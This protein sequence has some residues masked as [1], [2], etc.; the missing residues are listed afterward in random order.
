MITVCL[1]LCVLLMAGCAGEESPYALNDKQNFTV[2]IKYDANG[3]QFTTNTSVI[4]D[5][6]NISQLPANN[7]QVQLALRSPD[8][9][10][11]GND[12]FEAVRND[13]FLAGW[14]TQCT[15]KDGQVTYSGKWDFAEDRLDVNVS[16]DYKSAEPVLTL[17][18][19][20]VPLFEIQFYDRNSGE[21]LDTLQYNPLTESEITVPAWS[22]ETGAMEL[23]DFP[24]KQGY[25][26]DKAYYDAEGTRP[27]TTATLENLGSVNFANGTATNPVTKVYVDWTE[28]A[29]YHIYNVDQ[30]LEHA[31]TDGN[32]VIHADLDFTDKIWPTALMYGNFSGTI[33]GNGH[34]FSNVSVTQTNNSKP[35]AGLFG[36]LTETAG[37][38][39][40]KLENAV[41]TIQG[42]TRVMG[43]S[44]GLL[45]GTISDQAT[46]TGLEIHNSVL[47]I[48]SGCYFGV[49][50]YTIGLVCGMGNAAK[51]DVADIQCKAVGNAPDSV[52]I[53]VN[54]NA[55]SVE[56]ISE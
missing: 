7:G 16:G 55:V 25:T 15:E 2:S 28:G 44:F 49:D 12:A 5:S 1:L 47:Q 32:Y 39:D 18:A 43:T 31:S 40:L 41:F 50:D 34:T 19:A 37:I 30:F 4:V 3:G 17:Y 29:W 21:L 11:R 13:Y 52:K 53:Q 10:S 9:A 38:S 42:G 45:A 24:E 20:W 48:D 23:Y 54:G 6:Y 8:D 46:L 35:N 56:I 26:F 36:Q 14:Y 33:Q 51:V 22:M 27:V